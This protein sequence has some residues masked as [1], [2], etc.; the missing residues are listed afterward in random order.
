MMF[1][2]KLFHDPAI[3]DDHAEWILRTTGDPQIV[4]LQIAP[5]SPPVE[6]PG[7][8]PRRKGD[9]LSYPLLNFSGDAGSQR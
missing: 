8:G 3:D 4:P 7:S 9:R 5:T 1:E 2:M 6:G